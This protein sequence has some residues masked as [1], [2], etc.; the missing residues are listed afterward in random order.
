MSGVLLEAARNLRTASP[1]NTRAKQEPQHHLN[2]REGE[3]RAGCNTCINLGSNQDICSMVEE[4]MLVYVRYW[5]R[6]CIAIV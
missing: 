1:L 6:R 5:T 2:T 3:R 4:E